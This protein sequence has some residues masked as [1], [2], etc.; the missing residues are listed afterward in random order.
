MEKPEP[1][2]L[3]EKFWADKRIDVREIAEPELVACI[4]VAFDL[5][6]TIAGQMTKQNPGEVGILNIDLEEIFTTSFAKHS[7]IEGFTSPKAEMNFLDRLAQDFGHLER[8][9]CFIME[10]AHSLDHCLKFKSRV[11]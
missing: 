9:R 5:F 10:V 11:N 7:I 3:L 4:G 1:K 8:P 6:E 2:N